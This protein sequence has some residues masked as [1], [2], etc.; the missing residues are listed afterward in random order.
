MKAMEILIFG[1]G[2]VME[3][4]FPRKCCNDVQCICCHDESF[5]RCIIS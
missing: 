3:D 5:S 2:K 1:I 4:R